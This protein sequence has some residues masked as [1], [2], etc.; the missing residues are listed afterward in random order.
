MQNRQKY[1]SCG[2]RAKFYACVVLA[3]LAALSMVTLTGCSGGGNSAPTGASFS[4]SNSITEATYDASAAAGQ[5]GVFIDTSHTADGYI[6]ASGTSDSRL[7]LQVTSGSASYN[8]DVPEDGTPIIAPL[9]FGNGSYTFRMMQN[10]SGSNY[11]ELYSVTEN[12]ALS[13]EF[14]P[15]IRPNIFCDYTNTS[16]CVTLARELVASATNQGE[17][18][19]IICDYVIDNITYDNDKASELQ[20]TT[21]YIPNPDETLATGTGICFDYAS[22]GA[23]MLRSQGIPTR[24][25]TGYVSPDDIYHAWIMVCIDGTWQ[26]AEFSVNQNSWSRIDLTFAAGGTSQTIGDGKDYTDRYVY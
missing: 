15:Y 22:L 10:T 2:S 3:T 16:Q 13:D 4:V 25:V 20:T 23:A 17:A 7:K 6:G 14:A 24:I 12:V 21:G 19:E 9:T 5:N 11:V 18:V 8:Y 26:T 1:T